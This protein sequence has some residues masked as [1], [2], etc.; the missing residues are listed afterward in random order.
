MPLRRS[1]RKSADPSATKSRTPSAANT[2]PQP[3][4]RQRSQRTRQSPRGNA[5]FTELAQNIVGRRQNVV[6]ITGAGLSVASGVRPFRTSGGGGGRKSTKPVQQ[7]QEATETGFPPLAG[8]WDEVVYTTATRAAF[9]KDP[10]RWYNKFW[11]PHFYRQGSRT[12]VPNSGHLALDAL[13]QE[14]ENI[15]QVTQ[16]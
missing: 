5:G 2:G 8:I 11:I 3:K 7:R 10:L 4:K 13:L 16:K 14:N 6:F 15:R 9:R 12:P 1:P